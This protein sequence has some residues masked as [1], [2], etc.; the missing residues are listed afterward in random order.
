MD[1]LALI[2]M[3]DT[4]MALVLLQRGD[5]QTGGRGI[6]TSFQGIELCNS[7]LYSTLLSTSLPTS[8]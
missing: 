1:W 2:G 8:L 7:E 3:D 6:E 4:G 5:R